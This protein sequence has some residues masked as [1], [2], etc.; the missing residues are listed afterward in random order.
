MSSLI[1]ATD[2]NQIIVATDTL[3]VTLEGEPF[4]FVSKAIYIP[5]LRTIVAGTGASG[6]A[7]S[8]ALTI[9]NRMI[10]KGIM[11]LDYHTP[12]GL[13]RL[14]A[15]Y[16]K[17]YSPSEEI[18]TTVYQFGLSEETSKVKSFAYRSI[19]DFTSE[20]VSYG[21]GVKPKCSIP[22][23]TLLEALPAMMEEQRANQELM[24]PELRI[25]IGGEI[26]V[27]HLTAQCCTSFVAA[28]FQDFIEHENIIFENHANAKRKQSP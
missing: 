20:P 23:G 15:C 2:E 11:N 25:Y 5:H 26:Q 19:N 21:I 24:P 7:N 3:A 13:R 10:L 22:E 18:T 27:L 16:K 12:E 28:Q 4:A 17:E 14:W 9:S 6:F 1:F 8:W